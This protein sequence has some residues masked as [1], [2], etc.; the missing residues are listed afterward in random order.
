MGKAWRLGLAASVC[1][2]LAAS[3]LMAQEVTTQ[4]GGSALKGATKAK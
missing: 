3:P 1:G 2:L 4:L